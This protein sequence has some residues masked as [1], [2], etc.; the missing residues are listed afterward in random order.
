MNSTPPRASSQTSF[1]RCAVC[2]GQPGAV[3]EL[4]EYQLLG[5]ARKHGLAPVGKVSQPRG[6]VDSGADVVTF[7]AHPHVTGM[8]A[9]AEPDRRK[10]CLLQL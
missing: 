3:R 10:W 9:D 2:D 5:G 6:P 7:I 8:Y 4:V 1:I